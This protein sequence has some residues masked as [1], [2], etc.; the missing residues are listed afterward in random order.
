MRFLRLAPGRL[1]GDNQVLLFPIGVSMTVFR[2]VLVAALLAAPV[3]SSVATGLQDPSAYQERD[4]L[5]RIRRL[6]VEGKRGAG[7]HQT[8]ER[9]A[10]AWPTEKGD[11]HP[12]RI[13]PPRRECL[14]GGP[15]ASPRFLLVQS[16]IRA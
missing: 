14:Q 15:G 3:F 10:L 1:S 6:T 11:R 5:S 16:R 12:A 13:A 8:L 7:R 4:F 2:T 9:F